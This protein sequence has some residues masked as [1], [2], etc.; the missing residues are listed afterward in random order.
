MS[1]QCFFEGMVE[2]LYDVL[3]KSATVIG[4]CMVCSAKCTQKIL[5][6]ESV[7]EV[8][9]NS[10]KQFVMKRLEQTARAVAVKALTY[11]VEGV[12]WVMAAKD[13]KDGVN[14]AVKCMNGS[15]RVISVVLIGNLLLILGLWLT[16]IDKLLNELGERRSDFLYSRIFGP[17]IDGFKV[18]FLL[19]ERERKIPLFVHLY[20]AL[21]LSLIIIVIMSLALNGK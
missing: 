7:K 12:G 2:D 8:I 1:E 5:I 10:Y 19:K 3:V 4:D 14:C 9:M 6:G 16:S 18:V 21:L 17:Y 11:G 20:N 13:I 15:D